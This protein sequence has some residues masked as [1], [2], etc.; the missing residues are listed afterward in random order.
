MMRM[1]EFAAPVTVNS[2]PLPHPTQQLPC[3]VSCIRKGLHRT[4]PN[5]H[6]SH[7]PRNRLDDRFPEFVPLQWSQLPALPPHSTHWLPL[8]PL[9]TKQL[10]FSG[11]T[12]PN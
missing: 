7:A 12:I 11:H 5:R 6:L 2:F 3:N 4:K 1:T 8:R 9:P 10:S